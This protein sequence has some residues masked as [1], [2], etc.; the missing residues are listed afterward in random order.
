MTLKY[1]GISYKVTRVETG[2]DSKVIEGTYRGIT[3]EIHMTQ[4]RK[5]ISDFKNLITYRGAKLAV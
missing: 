2:A 3:T 1:R 4:M 5:T